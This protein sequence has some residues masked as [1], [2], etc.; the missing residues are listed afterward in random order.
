MAGSEASYDL[1]SGAGSGAVSRADGSPRGK[2]GMG[3]G[4]GSDDDDDDD[5]E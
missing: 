3:T 1:V 2:V 4:S 5:W